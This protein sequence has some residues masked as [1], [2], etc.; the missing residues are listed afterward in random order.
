V[1]SETSSPRIRPTAIPGA[2][3]PSTSGGTAPRAAPPTATTGFTPP[4][5]A[6]RRARRGVRAATQR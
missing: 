2:I 6:A 3:L 4:P 1:S 5:G